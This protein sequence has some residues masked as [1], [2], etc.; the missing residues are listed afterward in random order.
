MQLEVLSFS[1]QGGRVEAM[2]SSN[3][4]SIQA[5]VLVQPSLREAANL[6]QRRL[7]RG[8]NNVSPCPMNG[9]TFHLRFLNTLDCNRSQVFQTLLFGE[10]GPDQPKF[11]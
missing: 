7:S 2:D 3:V 8:R 1:E 9:I 6:K 4:N 10:K 11:P 5:R